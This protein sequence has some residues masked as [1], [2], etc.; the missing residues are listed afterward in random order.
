MAKGRDEP[1]NQTFQ[2]NF[3][4]NWF[5]S[6]TSAKESQQKRQKQISDYDKHYDKLK[7]MKNTMYHPSIYF[8]FAAI[9][10]MI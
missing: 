6:L 7:L 8:S 5:K 2:I 3:A 10:L 4:D 1:K 9:S